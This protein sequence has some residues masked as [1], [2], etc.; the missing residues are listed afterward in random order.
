M[1]DVTFSNFINGD[2]FALTTVFDAYIYEFDT[3]KYD[4]LGEKGTKK[5]FTAPTCKH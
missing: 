5:Y 3:T 1:A 4:P 2:K